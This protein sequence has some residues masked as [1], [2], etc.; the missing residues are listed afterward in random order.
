LLKAVAAL[1]AWSPVPSDKRERRRSKQEREQ[2]YRAA[3][4]RR[5]NRRSRWVTGVAMLAALGIAFITVLSATN[6][7]GSSSQQTATKRQA[8]TSTTSFDTPCPKANGTS[9]RKDF[10]RRPPPFCIQ[11]DRNYKA[12]I[13][14]DVGT[15]V[16]SLDVKDAPETVN[17]F[18]FLS[19][20]HFYDGIPFNRVKPGFIVQGGNPPAESVTGPGYVFADENVPVPPV[21]YRVGEMLMARDRPNSNGSQ[22]LIIVGPEG[23]NLPLVFS[24]FGEISEGMDVVRKIETDGAP[25]FTPKVLHT[26]QQVKIIES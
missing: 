6:R 26:I 25:D 16:V 9:P 5:R 3:M 2:A 8:T 22:F 17:N 14:T 19:R 13:Q 10:F 11:P 21:K 18:V 23:E 20:Y 1:L 7:S 12:Q 4:Q 15:F 24:L